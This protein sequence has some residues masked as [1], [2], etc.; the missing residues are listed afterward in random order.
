MSERAMYFGAEGNLLGIL[1]MAPEPRPGAPVVVLLNAGLLHRV[2]PNRLHVDIARRLARS[3][4]SSLRFDM[5]GVG[6]SELQAER[7]LYIERSV[8]DVIEAMDALD[9]EGHRDGYVLIG[10][11]TGAYNA[12]RAA[13]ADGRVRGCVLLDGYSYPTLRSNIQHYA[14]RI[15]QLDRWT[16]YI[17]RR[18]GRGSGSDSGPDDLIVFENEHVSRDRF[19]AE[20]GSLIERSTKLLLVY[21]ALGPLP[22]FYENQLAEALS[23]LEFDP[24]VTVRFYEDADHTFM[25][26]GHRE[27]LIDEIDEWFARSFVVVAEQ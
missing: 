8:R 2:G 6:D 14:P 10:L 9:A 20:L 13:L 7:L 12:F 3:G 25:L 21:T 24:W 16:R 17:A 22:Y 5:S 11:C 19:A 23:E 27:R 1:T 18:L 26:P 4:I 15:L